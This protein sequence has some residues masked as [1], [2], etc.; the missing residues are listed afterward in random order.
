MARNAVAAI[1][2]DKSFQTEL[3]AFIS[4]APPGWAMSEVM[5]ELRLCWLDTVAVSVGGADAEVSRALLRYVG[6]MRADVPTVSL[7]CAPDGL[8]LDGVAMAFATTAH[9]LDY[10]DVTSAW[11]GHPSAV[12]FPALTALSVPAR[13]TLRDILAAY[14]VGFEVGAVIGQTC[15]GRH[16]EQGWH[17]T[18]TIGVLA[19]TAAGSRLLGLS[20]AATTHALGLAVAQSAGVQANFGT[21]AKAIHAAFAAAAAVRACLLA[22]GGVTAS[23]NALDGPGGFL[24]LYARLSACNTPAINLGASPAVVRFGIERK[25]FPL[26]YAAHRAVEAA[27]QLRGVV[28]VDTIDRIEILGSPGAH[29]PLLK[30]LPRSAD[31]ARFSVEFGVACALVDGQVGLGSFR[32]YIIGRADIQ[33]ILRRTSVR[34]LSLDDGQRRGMVRAFKRDGSFEERACDSPVGLRRPKD[35]EAKLADC[36]AIFDVSDE[37][38]AVQRAFDDGLS[39]PLVDVLHGRVFTRLRDAIDERRKRSFDPNRAVAGANG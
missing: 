26:C 3:A 35:V 4:H 27:L 23:P 10:D 36:L 34:E 24:E 29:V 2:S 32:N 11:R 12:I 1:V 30:R 18:S 17:S 15:T 31:E 16:Y 25:A 19:A 20:A 28:D 37:A 22:Q 21:D 13:S 14:A 39:R 9:A 6:T 5:D 8:T 33:S 7:W 38:P